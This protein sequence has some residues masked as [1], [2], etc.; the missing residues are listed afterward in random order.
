VKAFNALLYICIVYRDF[1][2]ARRV[3]WRMRETRRI[4][5]NAKSYQLVVRLC[6]EAGWG[7]RDLVGPGC[8]DDA[9]RLYCEMRV[10]NQWPTL[11]LYEELLRLVG[12]YNNYTLAAEYY[13]VRPHPP[14]HAPQ[15]SPCALLMFLLPSCVLVFQPLSYPLPC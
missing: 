7:W 13:M 14:A 8:W 6:R 3:Y 1:K 11:A 15:A 4:K 12:S 10:G 2:E 9:L 5:L